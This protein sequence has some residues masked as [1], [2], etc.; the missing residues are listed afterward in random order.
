[1][2]LFI[3][4]VVIVYNGERHIARCL[5]SL[6]NLDLPSNFSKHNLEIIVVDNNS[7]DKTKSARL[8][9]IIAESKNAIEAAKILSEEYSIPNE[10]ATDEVCDF[11]EQL[12]NEKI[13]L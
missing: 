10:K 2:S 11:I 3:S 13:L 12:K 5:S 1:V 7:T 9:Q 8:W 6:L 4:I